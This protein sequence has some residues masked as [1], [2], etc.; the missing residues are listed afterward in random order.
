MDEI[1]NK[2]SGDEPIGVNSAISL[3]DLCELCDI[4]IR[5][6]QRLIQEGVFVSCGKEKG[7]NK[8]LY[9]L[10]DNLL[11]FWRKALEDEAK[12]HQTD[13]VD[14]LKAQKLKAEISLKESQ[15]ELHLLK[16]EIAKGNYISTADVALD[17]QRFFVL[18]KKFAMAIPARVGGYIAGYVD[19][20]VERG[21][22]KDIQRE[23]CSMLRNFVVAGHTPPEEGGTK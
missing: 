12:K 16:T 13:D 18:F 6:G 3:V 2:I 20:V 5:T 9:C 10:K 22:E 23:I 4:S 7:K 17:Y 1:N 15:G 14:E 11:S 19:P 21:I 8:N